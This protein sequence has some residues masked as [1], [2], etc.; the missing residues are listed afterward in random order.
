MARVLCLTPPTVV[1]MSERQAIFLS[2]SLLRGID[3]KSFGS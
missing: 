2:V 1:I 3:L